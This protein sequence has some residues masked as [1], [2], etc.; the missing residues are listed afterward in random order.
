[1][2]LFLVSSV[3][4]NWSMFLDICCLNGVQQGSE[5]G[6]VTGDDMMKASRHQ[7]VK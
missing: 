4:V 5:S 3:H 6:L 2:T 7:R 1:M